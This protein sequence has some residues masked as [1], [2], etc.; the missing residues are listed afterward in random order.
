MISSLEV[1]QYT[2]LG[3]KK[4]DIF[5]YKD[6]FLYNDYNIITHTIMNNYLL[7]FSTY[8]ENV[9]LPSAPLN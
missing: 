7:N 8:P 6:N 1:V 3:R 5:L 4:R 9:P 2:S